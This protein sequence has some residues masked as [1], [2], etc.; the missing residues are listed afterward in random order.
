[1]LFWTNPGSSILQNSSCIATCLL[2]SQTIQV[3]WTKNAEH[4]WRSKDELINNILFWTLTYGHTSI[5]WLAK[6]YIHQLC[7][8]IGCQLE[9]RPW[10]MDKRD[11]WWERKC[12]ENVSSAWL[13]DNY[14]FTPCKFFT[15]MLADAFSLDSKWQQ[16]SLGPQDS[17]QYSS[18]S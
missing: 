6:T 18:W 17:S 16:V 5:S 7:V 13:D 1:M 2:I 15:P 11:W 9:D 8:D 12:Q 4:C 3:R 14:Y 10:P